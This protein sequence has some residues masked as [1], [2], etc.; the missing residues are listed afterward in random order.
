M[1]KIRCLITMG[2]PSGIG[3][4]IIVKALSSPQVKSLADWT[5]IGDAW[6]F[7]KNPSLPSGRKNQ[8]FKII[9]LEN[10]PRKNFEFGKV[11]AEYGRA[12]WEY[13]EKAL[14]LIKA[15]RADCLV[16]CPINK[17]ALKLA[18][19]GYRGHTEYI[20]EYFG[21]KDEVMMLFNRKLR[22]SLVTQHISLKDVPGSLSQ[23][24]IFKIILGTAEG[25]AGLFGINHPKIA[26]CG[27]N[28]H[29]SDNGAIGEEEKQI[30]IPAIKKAR[31]KG[32]SV[33]GPYPADTI[34]LKA[35]EF[36][37]IIAMYHDQGLIPLKLTGFKGAVNVTLGLP[38]ARTS[39]AHGTAFDIAGKNAASAESLIQAIKT[40]IQCAQNLRK[41]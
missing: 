19:C 9:D 28:P 1:P 15:K 8:K 16:T 26:V 17:E 4:E 37:C 30:I 25:L 18:G 5:V 20:A 32:I 11:R 33:S 13:L 41:A 14:E 3:P 34:F 38:F 29:A 24:K 12:S 22:V 31:A 27:L 40:A 36:A 39:T 10:V 2:D 7:N 6:A 35:E 21:V 23:E